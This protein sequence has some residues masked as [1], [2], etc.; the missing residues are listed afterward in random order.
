[1][2]YVCLE[3]G[4]RFDKNRRQE[5]VCTSPKCRS[6]QVEPDFENIFPSERITEVRVAGIE[7]RR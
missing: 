6:A 5:P 2:W 1:M 3:C 7:A 4:K